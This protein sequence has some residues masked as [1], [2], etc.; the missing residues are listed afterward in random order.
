MT[1][2]YPSKYTDKE[3]TAANYIVELVCENRARDLEIP[4]P[5]KFW[6]LPE[7]KG[8]Y[9]FQ[10][11]QA[12]KLLKSLSPLSIMKA[13]RHT[14]ASSLRLGKFI[15]L[16]KKIEKQSKQP[17]PDKEVTL[18]KNSTGQFKKKNNLPTDL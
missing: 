8:Y 2:R 9:F 15:A 5:Y 17:V 7:W 14:N 11:K 18:V 6:N 3:V 12:Q 4:L 10:L 16:A 1:K 13:V